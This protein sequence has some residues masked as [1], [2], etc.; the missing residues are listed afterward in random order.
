MKMKFADLGR[1]S[2]SQTAFKP[3]LESLDGKANKQGKEEGEV[4]ETAFFE[5][6]TE[7]KMLEAVQGAAN[8]SARADAMAMLLAWIDDGDDSADAL[9]AYAQAL[10]DVDEDGEI[11][12]GDEQKAYEV[13]LTLMAEALVALGV[14]P[15]VA[16]GAMKGEETDAVKAFTSASDF[17]SEA[18]E[19]ELIA[20]FAV[21]ETMMLE[22][23]KKV[24]RDGKVTYIKKPLKKR[25]MSPAQK[26]ALKKARSKSNT[27][28]AKAA[29]KKSMRARSSRGM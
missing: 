16:M 1:L 8:Q 25:R 11:G 6:I 7:D 20:E 14:S 26:A 29:R 22:A 17:I 27:A 23:V 21:R 19:D 10:A 28:A 2:P 3:M 18:D 13:S 9:D 24:I 15:K 5:S 4:T 12:E